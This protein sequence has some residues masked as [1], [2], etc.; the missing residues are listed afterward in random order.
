MKFK[1]IMLSVTL[2]LAAIAL[3]ACGNN[4]ASGKT[5]KQ[6]L[7]LSAPAPLDTIDISKATG[8]GQT[9][10]VFE[11]FYRLGKNG[12]VTP[13]L[14]KSS[15]VSADG[16]TW[17]FKL[18]NA[19]WSN[20]DPI[21]AQDFVYS[22]RRT[23]DPKT[24]SSYAYMFDNVVNATAINEGKTSP[25]KLGIEAPDKKTVVVHLDKPVAYFKVLMA[26]PLFGPQNQKVAEKYGKKYA[27]KSQYMVYSGPFKIVD[28][29]G[30]GNKWAFVKNNQYWDKD[31]VKLHKINYRVVANTTTGYELY[32][33][34]KLDMTQLSNQQVKNFK[35]NKNLKKYPY[36]YV[37]WLEYNFQDP[38]ALNKKALNNK[39]IRLA[40]SL[41]V[42]RKTLTKKVL[43]DG[44]DT[45]Q[46]FVPSKLAY[47]PK[48]SK[49]FAQE[50]KVNNTVDYNVKLAKQ[51]WKKGMQEIGAKKLTLTILAA[52]DANGNQEVTQYLQ[53][54][55]S[56]VLPGLTVKIESIPGNSAADKARKGDFDIFLA[57]WGGDFNDPY[58]FMQIPETNTPY[59]RGKYSNSEYDAL[60][61]K[62]ENADA[63]NPEQR[64]ND[65][66]KAAQIF[67]TDQGITP[68]YEQ[69]NAFMQ[70]S[71]VKGI[72]HNTAGTQWNYKYAY[73]K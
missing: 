47:N 2:G 19:K 21:T 62:A 25:D 15:S 26:Y 58:T 28:W 13:G 36:S 39:N 41:A 12:K 6:T 73:M 18:R 11:S 16:K 66:V 32:Q 5:D 30:T 38:N 35:N 33:Q 22:W 42:D 3:A 70:R 65:L 63:N 61:E 20:G 29:N 14:A 7:N 43:G 67:N 49:D 10:N 69:T 72:I 17:T 55:Y 24:K 9:G 59:N 60:I 37:A 56:S 64:W 54:Q 27:T 52:N 44:S 71:N 34:G 31:V 1:K 68:L 46:G 40:L 51:Y 45:P 23:L 48:T 8:Y 50:Q 53:S 57:G 4:N